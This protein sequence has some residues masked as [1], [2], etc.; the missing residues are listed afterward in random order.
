MRSPSGRHLCQTQY[1]KPHVW[2]G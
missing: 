1:L 2:R